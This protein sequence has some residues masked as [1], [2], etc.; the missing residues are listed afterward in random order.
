[1]ARRATYVK[2]Q[3]KSAEYVLLLDAGDSLANDEELAV[4]TQGASSVELM[5]MLGYQAAALGEKD[6]ALGKEVLRSRMAEAKF[7]FLSANVLEKGGRLFAQPYTILEIGGHRI[8]IIGL[9]GQLSSQDFIISDPMTAA[10][11]YAA[12]VQK[13]A[14]IVILLS[15]LGME[16]NLWIADEVPGIDVIVS[17]GGLRGP[18]AKKSVVTG[19]LVMQADI[20]TRG[21]A[22]RRIGAGTLHFDAQGNLTDYE[23]ESVLLL[24]EIEDDPEIVKWLEA[25]K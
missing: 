21:H 2:R 16:T 14:D 8:G 3:R 23:W 6:L 18:Q 4:R 7:P 19:A 1:V 12:E 22:G 20:S 5:N 17:G 15:H 24:P 10:K 25:Q 9:T 11:R 13:Q